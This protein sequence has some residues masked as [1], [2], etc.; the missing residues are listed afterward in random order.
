MRVLLIEDD[1]QTAED[2][3]ALLARDQITTD[4]ASS[5]EAGLHKAGDTSI[6]VILLDWMLPGISGIDVLARLRSANIE[7]PVLMLSALGRAEHRVE[8]LDQGADDYLA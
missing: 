8:G 1:E 3:L 2:I 4:W 6:D 7:K 5:G